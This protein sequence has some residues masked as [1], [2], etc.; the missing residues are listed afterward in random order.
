MKIKDKEL[1]IVKR[2][3]K[4][5][6]ILRSWSNNKGF[7]GSETQIIFEELNKLEK[8]MIRIVKE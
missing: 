8:Y 5:W 2:F 3:G 1:L 6:A 7:S 4:S